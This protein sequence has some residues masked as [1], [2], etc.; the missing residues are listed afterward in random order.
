MVS[1][2]DMLHEKVNSLLYRYIEYFFLETSS[3]LTLCVSHL[4]DLQVCSVSMVLP[5]G[6]STN[7]Y[8]FI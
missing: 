5:G 6:G 2:A 8:H 7:L 3:K 1:T 4:D